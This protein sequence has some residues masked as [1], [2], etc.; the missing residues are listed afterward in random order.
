ML[1]CRHLDGN[2]HYF[3]NYLLNDLRDLNYLLDN[4][5]DYH[6]LFNDSL[7]LNALWNLHDLFNDLLFGCWDFLYLLKIDFLG[8]YPFLPDKDRNL[9]PHDKR[10]VLD[11]LNRPFFSEDYVFDDF[12]WDMFFH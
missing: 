8:D 10:H 4:P 2:L 7:D 11:N 5:R 12:N 3:F 1:D 6:D 9:L